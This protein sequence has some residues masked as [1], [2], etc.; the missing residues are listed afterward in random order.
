M[1]SYANPVKS[2]QEP[3]KIMI[4]GQISSNDSPKQMPSYLKRGSSRNLLGNH[5]DHS[6]LEVIDR[7]TENGVVQ[8]LH[9]NSINADFKERKS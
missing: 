1:P 8:P 9:Y 7:T 3:I 5:P 4:G 2:Y 6:I